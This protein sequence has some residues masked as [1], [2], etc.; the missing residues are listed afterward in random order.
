MKNVQKVETEDEA[1]SDAIEFIRNSNFF[2]EPKYSW[3]VPLIN[4]VLTDAL[5]DK[6]IDSLLTNQEPESIEKRSTKT[7]HKYVTYAVDTREIRSITEISSITNVGLVDTTEPIKLEDG[8]N[9]FYGKNGAG[10]SSVYNALCSLFGKAKKV[11]P[12]LEEQN[13]D[14]SCT[15]RYED[16]TGKEVELKWNIGTINPN[17]ATMIFDGQIAQVLVDNDQDNKFEIAHLKLEYFSYLHNLYERVE[18]VLKKNAASAEAQIDAI[19]YAHRDDLEFLFANTT[20]ELSRIATEM[21][22]T[23]EETRLVEIE[24]TLQTLSKDNPEAVV[25]NLTSVHSKIIEVLQAFGNK[26]IESDEWHL[27]HTKDKLDALNERIRI[28][29]ET[30]KSFEEGGINKLSELIPSDWVQNPLWNSFIAKSIEFTES[31]DDASQHKYANDNCIYCQ[32]KLSSPEARKLIEAYHEI[33][34]EHKTKLQEEQLALEG[35]ANTIE[36]TYLLK[37]STLAEVNALIDPELDETQ[38]EALLEV[39]SAAITAI[40]TDIKNSVANLTAIVEKEDE[41]NTLT[42][43]YLTYK[44]L[45]L[46]F[47]TKISELEAAV[48]SREETIRKLTEEAAPLRQKS[49]IKKHKPIIAKYIEHKKALQDSEEKNT[50]IHLLKQSTS[51]QETS[52]AKIA[53]LKEFRASLD[54]EYKH[55]GFV[56]PTFWNLKPVTKDGINK[57]SYSLADKKL[58]DIFSEGE[59]KLHALADFFAQCEV[60]KYKGVYIFDDPVNSLDE[61]NIVK[62]A[63]RI[64]SLAD[65]GNQIIVF[66]HNLYFLNA[67]DKNANKDIFRVSKNKPTNQVIIVKEKLEDTGSQLKSKMNTI[68]ARMRSLESIATPDIFEI[69]G[70]YDLISG[71]I[72]EYVEKK[73]LGNVV[74]RYRANIRMHSLHILS[75][76]T[77][78][79]I[80]LITE[81]YENA[82]RG[83]NRHDN[84]D[85]AAEPTF[86][87]LKD[88][89]ETLTKEFNYA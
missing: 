20:D 27:K 36:N 73:L 60:N 54:Q 53:S 89:V 65:K 41:L 6:D 33:T 80:K 13:T 88:D 42:S 75:T 34:T 25:R 45:E 86:Q 83:G 37:L 23:Q 56:P 70:V 9:I 4:K 38:K 8:L 18:A 26:D 87:Q 32:Q 69:G 44:E 7:I 71:Y 48:A 12:N 49:L 19:E 76:I 10:K 72:E 5:E 58:A 24:R 79:K 85:D 11:H 28:F 57:R 62:V 55:L 84:P 2:T 40:Y 46:V 30:K 47:R 82:S 31:L 50:H 52:F 14:T 68:T 39:D 81:L 66:T 59:R 74:S 64:L 43:F 15:I 77:D 35:I 1:P 78:E 29:K 63:K 21:P 16:Q 51:S 67:L 61:E 3:I 22:T 17:C